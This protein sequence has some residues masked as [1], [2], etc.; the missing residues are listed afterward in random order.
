L[1]QVIQDIHGKSLLVSLFSAFSVQP[2]CLAFSALNL[3]TLR[4]FFRDGERLA[5]GIVEA[6]GSVLL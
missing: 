3:A 1:N 5:V 2:S 4:L 6:F